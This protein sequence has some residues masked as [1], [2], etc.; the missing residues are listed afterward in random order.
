[1]D[2]IRVE[3]YFPGSQYAPARWDDMNISNPKDYYKSNG[4]LKGTFKLWPNS[5]CT[6]FNNLIFDLTDFIKKDRV[7]KKD[8]KW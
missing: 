2:V 6:Y 4:D 3:A 7:D 8:D 1:M 5:F